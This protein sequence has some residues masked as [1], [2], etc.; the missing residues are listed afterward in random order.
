MLTGLFISSLETEG[1][2]SERKELDDEG[3]PNRGKTE[4]AVDDIFTWGIS[5]VKRSNMYS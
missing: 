2:R 1:T 5:W 3:Q 4:R